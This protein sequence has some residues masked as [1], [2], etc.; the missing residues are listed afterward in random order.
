MLA[1]R[2][3]QALLDLVFPPRCLVCLA[4]PADRDFFCGRC[5]QEL[6]ADPHLT[7]PRCAATVGPYSLQ[8]NECSA[9]RQHPPAF[10]AAV[11]LGVYDGA[12]EQAVLRIK[13][14]FHEGLAERLG[15]RLAETQHPRF[16][17]MSLHA[18]VPVPLHWRKRLRRGYNQSAALAFGLG[19]RLGVPVR[20][21]W[22]SRTKPTP[23]QR[24][25]ASA[26]ARRANVQGAF[27]ARDRLDN[28]CILL[29]DDVMTTGATA[30]E[31][32]RALKKAGA[33]RVGVAV[34][35]RA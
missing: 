21:R 5:Q 23:E 27:R 16:S 18:I 31:A 19:Q 4:P 24:S 3:F 33:A 17:A 30:S 26:A 10:D 25:M 14:A 2:P 28:L 29:V 6:F 7:C 32:A 8:E 13:S 12:L 1:L 9:C 34:L 20:S 35:A 11:R 22:L 15:H